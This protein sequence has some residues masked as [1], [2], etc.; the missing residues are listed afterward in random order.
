MAE[1]RYTR[2]ALA[3]LYAQEAWLRE[4]NPQAGDRLADDVARAERLLSEHPLSGRVV[5]GTSLRVMLTRRYKYRLFYRARGHVIVVRV[6]HPR[7]A[8]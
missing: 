7:E 6:L 4:R 5:K 2:R 3:D 8:G 1:V